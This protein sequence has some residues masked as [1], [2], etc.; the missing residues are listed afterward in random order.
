MKNNFDEY[1][2]KV[3]SVDLGPMSRRNLPIPDHEETIKELVEEGNR[4]LI[5]EQKTNK[6]SPPKDDS[7]QLD[8]KLATNSKN[9][10]ICARVQLLNKMK[11]GERKII[12]QMEKKELERDLRYDRF[13]KEVTVLGDKLSE[14]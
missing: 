8:T 13:I 7:K 11:E 6:V 4:L 14:K 2:K 3:E 10:Y 9:P 12:E 5:E 1:M